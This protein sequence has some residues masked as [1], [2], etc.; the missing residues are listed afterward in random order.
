[1]TRCPFEGDLTSR[2]L[3]DVIDEESFK[4]MKGRNIDTPSDGDLIEVM[5]DIRF[6]IFFSGGDDQKV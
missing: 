5:V 6:G 2:A 1:M 3:D 4:A